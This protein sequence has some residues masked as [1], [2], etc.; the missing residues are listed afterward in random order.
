[1]KQQAPRIV[2][3]AGDDGEWR[4]WAAISSGGEIEEK[5]ESGRGEC[6]PK[7]ASAAD[8]REENNTSPGRGGERW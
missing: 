1:M 7:A 5:G 6:I 3:E 2:V 4:S 8:M